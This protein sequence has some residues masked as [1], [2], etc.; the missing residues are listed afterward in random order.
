M[1][2]EDMG[3][4]TATSSEVK[5]VSL[6]DTTIEAAESSP[7][8]DDSPS[9]VI[10]VVRDVVDKRDPEK[11]AAASS[12]D[13]QPGEGQGQPGAR[14]A[15]EPD[16][17]NYSD[18]PFH[19]H[20]RF[21]ELLHERNSLRGEAQQFR[22]V[23]SYLDTN[24]ITPQAMVDALEIVALA[25]RDPGEAWKRL[26]PFAEDVLR[27]TGEVLPEDLANRVQRGEIS[28]ADALELNKARAAHRTLEQQTVYDRQMAERRQQQEMDTAIK[29]A[30]ASWEAETYR[31]DPDLPAKADAIKKEVYWLQRTEGM[32]STPAGVREQL[33][34]AYTA[35]TK[36]LAPP[37]QRRPMTPVTG[38][39]PAGNHAPEPQSTLDIIRN[40]KARR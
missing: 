22:Q 26:K 23:Q 16:P 3:L 15:K 29:S 20:P 14:G 35:V 8:T 5:D 12:A 30:A 11:A 17:E 38:G 21:K 9:S 1:A 25:R 28:K 19:K 34:K 39:R 36:Q 13:E 32:P 31:K 2:V 33:Q 40:V 6:V 7:A 18:V 24:G 4:D 10:D 37:P 27:R